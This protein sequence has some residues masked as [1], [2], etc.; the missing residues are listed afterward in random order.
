MSNAVELA[1]LTIKPDEGLRLRMYKCPAGFNTVGYGFNL[2]ANP[3]TLEVAELLLQIKVLET[4]G[5]CA[6]Y[7][8]WGLLNDERK[9]CLINLCYCVG[10][11]GFSKFK[12]MH[13]ALEK[14][15]YMDAAVEMLDSAF[16]SQTGDRAKR[17]ATVM[18]DGG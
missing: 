16:A 7:Q 4:E 12:R 15:E 10:P 14:G 9:A 18:R 6:D 17:L 8:Y 3:I 2:D 13:A 5:V 11:T 1:K